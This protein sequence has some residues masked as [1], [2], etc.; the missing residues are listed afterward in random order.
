MPT[1]IILIGDINADLSFVLPN[2]PHS[3]D[4]VM[5][6]EM[7]WGSGGSALNMALNFA[8]LGAQPLV[9]GRIGRDPAAR[10][11]L[12]AAHHA[13]LDLSGIQEDPSVETGLCGVLVDE[14]GQRSFLSYRGAN[15]HCN[16][17][18]IDAE[19]LNNCD[20]LCICGHALIEGRQ[21]DTALYAIQAANQRNI[22]VALDLCLPLVRHGADVL[23]EL[24]PMLWVL[25]MNEDEARLLLPRQSISQILETLCS[26]GVAHIAI[27]RGAQ[28]CSVCRAGQRLDV[29]PPGVNVIDTTGAGDAFSAGFAWGLLHQHDLGAC[30]TLGNV[31]GALAATRPGAAEAV[32]Q[33]SEILARLDQSM[34]D[35]LHPIPA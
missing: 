24:I 33:R 9:I 8:Q 17:N 10:I 13:G 35:M 23:R 34:H 25:S 31:L 29:L 28:G 32:P 3:G 6:E 16:A 20:L 22:P 2:L 7:R 19:T 1:S 21:R 5:V 30:A 4:D 11:A 26:Q 15:V 14:N 12:R 27:K 18:R